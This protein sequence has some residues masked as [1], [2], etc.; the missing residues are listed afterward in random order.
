[1]N[2]F[3]SSMQLKHWIIIAA[4]VAAVVIFSLFQSTSFQVPKTLTQGASE[5]QIHGGIEPS[6]RTQ[7][8]TNLD[9]VYDQIHNRSNGRPGIAPE[10]GSSN[11]EE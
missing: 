10:G 9:R 11:E 8:R 1:M 5:Q 2:E 4:V 3:L 7:S 6:G